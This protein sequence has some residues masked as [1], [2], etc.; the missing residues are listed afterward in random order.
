LALKPPAIGMEYV[1]LSCVVDI[2]QS[3]SDFIPCL[4]LYVFTVIP[5]LNAALSP[6][7]RVPDIKSETLLNAIV[8]FL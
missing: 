6:D 1:A 2:I 3:D 5:S 4:F 7:G 8:V